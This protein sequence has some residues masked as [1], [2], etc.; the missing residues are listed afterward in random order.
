MII[1]RPDV[2]ISTSPTLC[3]LES[4][5]MILTFHN[6]SADLCEKLLGLCYRPGFSI[7]T[8]ARMIGYS[9]SSIRQLLDI[10]EADQFVLR[11]DTAEMVSADEAI[12]RSRCAGVFWNKFVISRPFTSRLF[13]GEAT[14]AEVIGWALEFYQFVRSAREYMARGASRI[15]GSTD[16]LSKL[17][18]HFA[19]EAF[20]DEIFLEGLIGCNLQRDTITN[21]LPLASTLALTNF[22][23]ES[24]EAGELEYCSVFALMQPGIAR[25][26]KEIES[27]YDCLRTAYPFAKTIFDAFQKHDTIDLNLAHSQITLEPILRNRKNI[28]AYEMASIYNTIRSTAEHFNIFFS[29]ISNHYKTLW[30]CEYRQR[31]NASAALYTHPTTH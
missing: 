2:L 27:N 9:E 4:S 5:E 26:A 22:L 14:R 24:A 31:P 6:K 10:L 12:T 17:W 23:W 7:E 3:N 11:T 15:S 29:G 25:A 28:S 18:S 21:R 13:A 8:A 1:Q 30:A 20:H 16:T 19:E